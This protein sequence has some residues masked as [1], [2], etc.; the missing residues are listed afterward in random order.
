[1]IPNVLYSFTYLTGNYYNQGA[2]RKQELRDSCA[3][4]GIPASQITIVQHK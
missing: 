2:Q 1:M 4:L 3:V